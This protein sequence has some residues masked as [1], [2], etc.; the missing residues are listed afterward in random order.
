MSSKKRLLAVDLGASGG[1]CFVGTFGKGHFAMDE[2][3]RFDHESA[4]F[5]LA[6]SAGKVTERTHWNDTLIYA[7]IIKGLQACRRQVAPE[8]DSIGIDTWGAD[9]QW[10]SADGE[11]LGK[12]YGYRDH[13]LD[14]MVEALCK[15]ISAEQVYRITGI[16]FQPFNLSNQLLWFVLNRNDLLKAA[17]K[18]LPVPSLLNYYLGGCTHIDSTWASVTQL[19]DARRNRWS[20]TM[21]RAIGMPL[22]L[23]PEIVPPGTRLGEL[24]APL[25]ASLGLNAVPI[26]AV[27]SHDTA[28]AFA[29]APVADTREA[30]II[31][32]GTWSLIGRLVPRPV[33][34]P[35]AHAANLSNEGGIGN[36]RLLRNC[37]G[38]WIVQE[39]LRVWEA[40]DGQRMPWAEVDRLQAAAAPFAAFIDP[41]DGGFYNPPDMEAAIREYLAR[42]GQKVPEGRGAMLRLVYESL[43][44]KYRAVNETL[45][46][47]TRRPSRV[48]HIVGGGCN[49]ELLNQFTA[50]ALGLPVLAGPREATAVGNLMVQALGLGLIASLTDAQPLIRDAFPIKSYTPGDRAPWDAAYARFRSLGAGVHMG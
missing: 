38:S 4:T 26:M 49:N 41:D 37:M 6:D 23:L 32:S 5:F 31:S 29:A 16:H 8:L 12:L 2:I 47:V 21:L 13:R 18:V 15:R 1:K 11:T 46:V 48:V 43:A 45:D 40:A 22:K 36:T 30:L 10:I 14:N 50:D 28:S 17:V 19:M 42:T 9:A 35:D 34:T 25:A 44:L 39:L 33:T 3:H 20:R 24:R 7:E 27:G